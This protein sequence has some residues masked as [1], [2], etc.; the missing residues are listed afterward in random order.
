MGKEKTTKPLGVVALSV[1]CCA[2]AGTLRA[3]PDAPA[4]PGRI[5]HVHDTTANPFLLP[6]SGQEVGDPF[7][8]Y[9]DGVWHLYALRADLRAVL[10]FTSTDLVT[11]AE[12]E[13]AMVGTGIATGTVVRDGKTFYLFYT[14]A[15]PQT[16]RLVVSDNP[17]H[18]DFGKSRL[19][20]KADE[21]V[22][23]LSHRKFRDCYVF[24]NEEEGLWWMLVEATSDNAVAA[25]LFKSKDLLTW[26]QHSPIF[27]DKS[28]LHG[29]CPQVFERNGRWNLTCLDYGTWHY[30]AETPYGP[31][32]LRGQYHS[33]YFTAASRLA[34]A[35]NRRLCWGFFSKHPTPERKWRGYGGPLG[36][37][38][39]LVF[40]DD[41]TVGVRPLAELVT[42]IRKPQNNAELFACARERRGKW[43]IDSTRE[44]FE[45]RDEGGG[46]LL[47]DLP[48]KNP[49]Y[50]FEADIQFASPQTRADVVVRTSKNCDRGYRVAIE[51][52]NSKIAIRQFKPDGGTFNEKNYTFVKGQAVKLQVF[53]C[54]GQIEAFVGER[55]SLSA[56][57]LDRPDYRVAIEIA[58]GRAAIG[59]PLLH[60]FKYKQ[61]N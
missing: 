37:G 9:W 57:V 38:R 29:S 8:V 22:Y 40:R 3:Q 44:T 20:A 19:V 50:Y 33:R 48:E 41:G 47:W 18:F 49:D 60:Y 45:S 21:K 7:P 34:T 31:W 23:Q 42:A 13:P 51:P 15:G 35:G 46:V 16:I 56:R 52:G 32:S 39:E 36:V 54:G 59:K 5:V 17:W 30:T 12:R 61:G 55:A 1:W 24:R 26:R 11:W 10:H 6:Q 53:V 27:K 43:D 2:V 58:G 28:R 4:D 25:G 14:D